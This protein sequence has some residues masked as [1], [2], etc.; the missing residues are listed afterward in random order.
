MGG[1]ACRH[2]IANRPAIEHHDRLAAARQLISRRQ[3]G[4]ARADDHRIGREALIEGRSPGGNLG[5]HPH[6]A[7]PFV[8]HV[9]GAPP[10]LRN[11]G[12]R[13]LVPMRRGGCHRGSSNPWRS[14][15]A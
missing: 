2:A 13:A 12:A 10:T 14:T 15:R 4:Y 3:A 9:H 7:G 1:G 11:A 8:A 5:I 6:R